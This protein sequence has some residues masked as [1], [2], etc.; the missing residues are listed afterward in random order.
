MKHI[1]LL[2]FVS[3]QLVQC[4]AQP[5]PFS[6]WK[7]GMKGK[8]RIYTNL[9]FDS[10]KMI[11]GTSE[12]LDKNDWS[13]KQITYLD[14]NCNISEIEIFDI[15]NGLAGTLLSETNEYSHKGNTETVVSYDNHGLVK[16][17]L[18][19]EWKNDTIF[20][21]KG[22]K[23][24][25]KEWTDNDER[26]KVKMFYTVDK[27]GKNINN[28]TYYISFDKKNRTISFRVQNVSDL[29]GKLTF[30]SNSEDDKM[31]NPQKIKYSVEGDGRSYLIILSS[32]EYYDKNLK[33]QYA[34]DST[35]TPS[36]AKM[37]TS[38]KGVLNKNFFVSLGKFEY[39]A[40]NQQ[41]PENTAR[42][43]TI[44][45]SLY[46]K[47]S[48][49][50][51]CKFIYNVYS[52]KDGGTLLRSQVGGTPSYIFVA[53][54]DYTRSSGRSPSSTEVHYKA[55]KNGNLKVVPFT[56]EPHTET[57]VVQPLLGN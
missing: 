51:Q 2:I 54:D 6:L 8:V 32:F 40:F 10:T 11:P 49:K 41:T 46:L 44:Y 47:G 48:S 39:E 12:I 36:L 1:L 34:D 23:L 19:R 53:S 35:S 38:E 20:E 24:L 4:S 28:I 9:Y 16:D 27:T 31:G 7:S 55:D 50:L 21:T 18:I 57:N 15:Y 43:D 3:C 13:F 37:Q 29:S 30:V 14:D 5:G 25:S 45:M 17:T 52:K 22:S 56:P 26:K 42:I 33:K